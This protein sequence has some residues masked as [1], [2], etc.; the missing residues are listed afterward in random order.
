MH[1][2]LLFNIRVPM[3]M[4][5]KLFLSFNIQFAIIF[6]WFKLFDT[7]LSISLWLRLNAFFVIST[8]INI[9][10]SAR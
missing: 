5:F 4:Q 8:L 6:N 9:F 3:L 10:Y 7:V 2:N 1:Y